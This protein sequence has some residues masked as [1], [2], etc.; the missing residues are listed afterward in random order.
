[1]S[2]SSAGDFLLKEG[3]EEK[4]MGERGGRKGWVKGEGERGG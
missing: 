4:G 1:L 2:K 3:V